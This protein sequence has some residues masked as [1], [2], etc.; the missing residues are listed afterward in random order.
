MDINILRLGRIE[1]GKALTL[2]E[3]LQILRQQEKIGDTLIMLEH[4]PVITLGRR[5]KVSNIKVDFDELSE[6]KISVVEVSRGGDVTFHGP[7]QIVGYPIFSL[8]N[9]DKDIKKFIRLIESALIRLLETEYDIRVHSEDGKYTGVWVGESKIAA[10]GI[11]V[12]KYVTMH[13][14]A[15]NVNTDLGFFDLITPCGLTDRSVTSLQKLTGEKHDI[16]KVMRQT[17]KYF[18]EAFGAYGNHIDI[19]SMECL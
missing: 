6:K 14:F 5:G 9:H 16:E 3:R 19:G 4:D 8:I 15:L 7:G 10:I 2:Q 12:K 11:G 18:C 1:Y 17:E 13:G